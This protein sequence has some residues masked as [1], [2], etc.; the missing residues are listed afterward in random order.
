[1][2]LGIQLWSAKCKNCKHLFP[3]VLI[4]PS[5]HTM[6][7][8]TM[9]RLNENKPLQE[10][11]PLLKIIRYIKWRRTLSTISTASL[12]LRKYVLTKTWKVV[13]TAS[14]SENSGLHSRKNPKQQYLKV[15]MFCDPSFT[16]KHLYLQ[17]CSQDNTLNRPSS[18]WKVLILIKN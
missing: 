3:F 9:A 16:K 18:A 14:I 17:L 11:K 5:Y 6:Q 8:I 12:K 4:R 13:I 2:V 10:N 15:V 7:A 1:M